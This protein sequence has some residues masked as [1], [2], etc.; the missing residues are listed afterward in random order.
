MVMALSEFIGSASVILLVLGFLKRKES[1][2]K[3][4][5]LVGV[6]LLVLSIISLSYTDFKAGFLDGWQGR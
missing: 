3:R 6:L 4:A 2:G 1:W 5:I